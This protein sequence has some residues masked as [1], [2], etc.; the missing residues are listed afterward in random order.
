MD[1]IKSFGHTNINWC[2]LRAICFILKACIHEQARFYG[3]A[4][5]T[6]APPKCAQAPPENV[7]G[8]VYLYAIFAYS[9]KNC[10]T[11]LLAYKYTYMML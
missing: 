2:E 1:T 9:E 11:D 8:C 7:Q 4:L 10:Q 5:G 3:G 6:Q